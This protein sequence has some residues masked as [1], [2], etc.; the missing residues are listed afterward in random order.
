MKKFILSLGIGLAAYLVS[1]TGAGFAVGAA[2]GWL[3]AWVLDLQPNESTRTGREIGRIYGL[4]IGGLAA[5]DSNSF[6][7]IVTIVLYML[8]GGLIGEF[9]P[10]FAKFIRNLGE[11]ETER[12]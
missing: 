7:W 8:I 3:T 11:D 12:A 1:R 4:I 5:H 9:I 6:V 10:G 2:I